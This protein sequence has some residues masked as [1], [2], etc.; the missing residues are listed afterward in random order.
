MIVGLSGDRLP[1]AAV[2]GIFDDDDTRRALDA[3]AALVK[4]YI[5]LVYRG[6]AGVRTS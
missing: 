4:V 1:V 6:P 3:G 2:G 5:G